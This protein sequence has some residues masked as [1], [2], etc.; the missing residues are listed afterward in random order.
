MIYAYLFDTAL[1]PLVTDTIVDMN[2]LVGSYRDDT[3]S[4]KRGGV[5][6]PD[7]SDKSNKSYPRGDLY[8][9]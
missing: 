5:C 4:L 1:T 8:Q 7:F 6:H 2:T 3:G 9:F